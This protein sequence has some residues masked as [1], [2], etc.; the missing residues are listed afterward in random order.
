MLKKSLLPI[1]LLSMLPLQA[2]AR[3]YSVEAIIFNHVVADDSNVVE[4]DQN[5]PRNQRAQ[6]RLDRFYRQAKQAEQD[7]LEAPQ[8]TTQT[9]GGAAAP[10][11]TV[12][13]N[14]LTELLTIHDR[15]VQSPDHEILQVLSWKQ[16]EANYQDSPLVPVF[17]PHMMGV[18][19]VYAPNLL[20]TELNLLYTPGEPLQPHLALE[21][22]EGSTPLPT[23]AAA[24]VV[25][26]S[27]GK[28]SYGPNGELYSAPVPIEERYY[29][30]EQRKLK[31]NEIHYFDHPR[32][33]VILSVKPLEKAAQE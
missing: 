4:W 16:S 19:R 9:E 5:A 32:F 2:Q 18:L 11:E 20:F 29:I 1:L 33:G 23:P 26:T 30:D 13:V 6:N 31:L 10:I 17:T 24:P 27:F 3:D 12:V 25:E 15:L 21:Q 22:G 7:R 8:L 28:F 14:E